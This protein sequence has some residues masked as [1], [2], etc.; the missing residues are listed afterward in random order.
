MTHGYM[1]FKCREDAIGSIRVLK[2]KI[3]TA[4]IL[5]FLNWKKEFHVHVDASCI[6]LGAVLTQA[7][8]GELDHHIAFVS[9]NL[10][11]VEKHYSMT[12]NKGSAMVYAL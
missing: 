12:K 3:V 6:A 10:S 7:G 9:S 11:K 5:V 4:S 1:K 2:E 8:E